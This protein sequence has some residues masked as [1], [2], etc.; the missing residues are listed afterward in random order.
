MIA[1]QPLEGQI[2]D[3]PRIFD[4]HP[5]CQLFWC[6]LGYQGFNQLPSIIYVL[7]IYI[8]MQYICVYIYIYICMH[9]MHLL[10]LLL[11]L[12]SLLLLLYIYIY[13]SLVFKTV[14][15]V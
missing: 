9:N 13:V 3:D 2:R 1:L 8:Y 4:E 5:I 6:S 14:L 11:L 7:Y 12:L 10:L 15:W